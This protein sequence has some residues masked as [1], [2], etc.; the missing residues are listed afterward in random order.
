[1]AENTELIVQENN[2]KN[3]NNSILIKKEINNNCKR[4]Y[5][6]ENKNINKVKKR[7]PGIDLI[8]I[9][10]M[11]S[12]IIHHILGHGLVI[13]KYKK[14]K[15]LTFINICCNWH[16]NS[17]ELV[18]G[19]IGYKT[20]KYS[21]LIYL[22]FCVV[23]YQFGIHYIF[24]ITNK[25]ININHVFVY[26]FFPVIYSK[27]WY[28]TKYFGMYIFLPII[29][30]GIANLTKI[31]QKLLIYSFYII[32]IIWNDLMNKKHDV[33]GI[34]R[35][36]SIIW[37]SVSFITGA[38]I[39][40]YKNNIG[41][42]KI[43]KWP[44]LITIYIFSSIICYEMYYYQINSIDNT[45]LIKIIKILKK[46]FVMRLNS[47][48]MILQSL[49]IILLLKDIS[50]NK[51][52][53]KIICFFGPLTFGIY[54][55]HEHELIKRKFIRNLFSRDSNNLK[56]ILVV[57][58]VFIRSIY[59]FFICSFID[60]LRYIIFHYFLRIK[61]ICLFIEKNIINLVN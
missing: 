55:L 49:S 19:I 28:F 59:I 7:Y 41:I 34:K 26:D 16:V 13:K 51:Y 25:N 29:N 52:I 23:G 47:I 44:L 45:F 10:G 11:W 48:P 53:S 39:G 36:Y 14:Y 1:M 24:R 18:S 17:F 3:D 2:C 4:S 35:G 30:R 40:K 56:K 22:W 8:R 5:N 46:I 27:Y 60:Y 9:L 33:F 6:I 57:K 32:Y 38:Y 43:V 12:I 15:I 21:N 31:E 42:K 58:L 20:N 61:K 50:Y 37:F 54:L